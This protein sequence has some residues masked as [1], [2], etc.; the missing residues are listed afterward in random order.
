[1]VEVSF[2]PVQDK[3]YHNKFPL[4]IAENSKPLTIDLRGFGTCI[5]LD[6]VPSKVKIGP[7]LPYDP[8]SYETVEIVN[9]TEYSTEV[10]S[11][12][13][14]K[15]YAQESNI[16]SIY[17]EMENSG[18]DDP[19]YLPV[20]EAGS[21]VW[22]QV[23]RSVEAF[24]KLGE[25]EKKLKEEGLS[26]DDKERLK[27]EIGSIVIKEESVA[28]PKKVETELLQHIVLFGPA[29]SGKSHIAKLLKTEHNR[30]ILNLDELLNWNVNYNTQAAAEAK[31]F[32][33][34]RRKEYETALQER[35]KLFKK[36]GKKAVE[37]EQ[38]LGPS[39]EAMYQI[40][41]ESIL[42]DLLRERMQHPECGAG[43]IFDGLRSRNIGNELLALKV[44]MKAAGSQAVQLIVL[45]RK[46]ANKEEKRN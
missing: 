39:M 6:V 45:D 9:P 4:R 3:D 37:V 16:I 7:V 29:K 25:L 13:F 1:M 12:D 42:V 19:L 10:V 23:I 35:E 21:A 44:I 20:R 38:R 5:G 41:P 11:L 36:L 34:E 28:Y 27:Q 17:E 26:G 40:L 32:L 18:K 2:F 33:E 22:P 31:D 8:F 24:K 30:T 14:D 46:I 15:A 43:C